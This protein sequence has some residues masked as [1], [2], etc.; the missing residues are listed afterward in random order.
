MK[1]ERESLE[2]SVKHTVYLSKNKMG[3]NYGIIMNLKIEIQGG[4]IKKEG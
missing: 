1:E 4:V 3:F 2:M